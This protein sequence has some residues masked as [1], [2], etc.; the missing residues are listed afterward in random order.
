MSFSCAPE[1]IEKF[2]ALA[3]NWW[4][5]HGEMK[6][7]HQLNPVRFE[8]IQKFTSLSGKKILDVGCGGGILTESLAKAGAQAT[9]IDMSEK[10]IQVAAHHAKQNH[11]A[12]EYCMLPVEILAQEKPASFDII[13]C[14]ELLEH[15]PDP[16]A[17]IKACQQL[18]K[19]NGLIFFSTLNRT[20]KSFLIAIVGAEYVLNYLPKGTH[21]YA[22]FIRPSELH[23]LAEKAGLTFVNLQGMSYR[24]L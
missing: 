11:L 8:Y 3:D 19:E 15:V 5:P 9:G 20:L 18:V 2:N 17:I 4:N 1:E 24:P 10:L 23:N 12:I 22:K 21:E 6:P 7:L 13:T 14:M 16:F